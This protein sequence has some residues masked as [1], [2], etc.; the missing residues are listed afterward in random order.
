MSKSSEFRRPPKVIDLGRHDSVN[1]VTGNVARRETLAVPGVTLAYTLEGTGVPLLVAGSSVY[2]PRTFSR[3]LRELC[4]L[5]CMDLP[6]FAAVA[7]DFKR[8]SITFDAYARHLETVRAAEELERVVVVGHSHHG[9]VALEYAKRYPRRVSHIVMIG[10]PPVDITGTVKE[11]R[12][13]W[14]SCASDKRKAILARRR[15]LLDERSLTDLSPTDA[16]IAQYV[17]DA[18]LY[19]ND[20]E[21]DASWL[22]EGM[23]FSMEAVHAFRDLYQDYELGWDGTSLQA[24]VLVVMGKQD[25]AVP[26]TLWERFLPKHD[27]ITFR[28]LEHSGHTPQL[29]QPDEFDHILLEWIRSFP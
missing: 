14:D 2:Y 5:V 29:E 18:P 11:A 15:G 27:N 10:S 24:P 3:N 26:H 16:Y 21:Y 7:R 17:A 13:Y 22:W 19:W 6:H 23:T 9:N 20:P 8:E 25:Y 4:A 28:L 12:R 1:L